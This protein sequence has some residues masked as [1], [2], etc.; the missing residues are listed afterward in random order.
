MKH[1]KGCTPNLVA[2]FS[3]AL[4][5]T[6]AVANAQTGLVATCWWTYQQD[7]NGNGCQAGNLP[8][9][10]A[11][12]NWSPIVDGCNGT[13]SVFE[14]VY[15]QSC[16]SGAWVPF[17]TNAAHSITGCRSLG[18]Q[19]LDVQMGSNCACQ[20]YKVA[21]Y[22]VGH[23]TPDDIRSSTNEP[24]LAQHHEELL[25]QDFCLSDFFATCA[26]LS[27]ASGSYSDETTYAT[28]E[29]GE[30]N[31]AGNPGG[32]SLWYCWTA[33]TNL[34]ITFDTLGSTFDTLLA[35]YTG[36]NVSNLTLIGSNDDIAGWTNRQSR[37]TFTPVAGATYHIVVD[38]FG[39]AT[40]IAVLNWNQTGA[41][42]PD[43][44]VW[45]DSAS[46][47]VIV[48]TFHSNDCEVVEGC[49]PAGQRTLLSFTTETRNV[50][51]GD[52]IMG[53]PSTN[54]LFYWAT[55]HAHWHFE[56]FCEYNLLD[57]NNNIVATGHKVGFCLED[58]VNWSP[59]GN[60]Q[61]KYDCNYQGIQAG[62]ADVYS[63]G[64]PCQ[65]ID[66]TG[67]APGSY[68]LQMIVNPDGIIPES[69]TANNET[70]VAV[71][72]PPTG[73][74]STPANDNFANAQIVNQTPYTFTEF[75]Q[76]ATKQTGEPSHAGNVGGNSV[77]FNWT[78]TSNHTAVINTKNSDFDTLLAVYT[79]ASVSTLSVVA[80]NDD[81]A[82]GD[83]I[84]SQVTFPAVAG[85][86]YHIAV[87]GFND[88]VNGAAVGTVVLNVNPPRN[89]DFT[90]GFTISG[91]TGTTNGSNYAASKVSSASVH[92][93]AHAGDVGGHSL[94]YNWIAPMSGPVDFNTVG[95]SINTDLA[96]YTGSV[97]S[98]LTVIAS[99]I[100]DPAG[101]GLASRVDFYAVS[102]TTYH[103]VVDGFGGAVGNFMLNWNMDSRLT[104]ERLPDGDAHLKLTGVDWQRY[105]L[106]G[107]SNL[108]SWSTNVPAITM[109]GGIHHYTNSP[110][111]NSAGRK[112]FRAFRAP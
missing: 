104:I 80:S 50:G 55:C 106:L 43:L 28:K 12:L 72:I 73:C 37:V 84:Q 107:S 91:I 53:D 98:N 7:C 74:A 75:N 18:D 3:F 111:T 15:R 46:P 14:I 10:K 64:L 1:P 39:G 2:C 41:A 17:Y 96:V 66:I 78:P 60:P 67:I 77:W 95:S 21:L 58:V 101:A 99:N 87:D 47:T 83:Y 30:P 61:S 13:I 70:R 8:G 20:N 62:W 48:R 35:V 103:V 45:G 82:F 79:G 19:Y 97:F 52:L 88:A 56:Q 86:T 76:C 49:E 63:A 34:P 25:S 92:E 22:R 94:W 110:G 85:T 102:G 59:S 5:L 36:N 6:T 33:P 57:T 105:T 23:S 93:R 29:A 112:F 27:G 81:I 26:S 38:G 51:T 71:T 44:V 9:N 89:D 32:H 31:H 109:M 16:S 90:N 42:L 108:Q 40:G 54:S 24:A 100:Q 11:R 69:N 4:L 65:Y 68:I